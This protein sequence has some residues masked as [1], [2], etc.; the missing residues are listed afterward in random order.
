MDKHV[1]VSLN[2]HDSGADPEFGK[3]VHLVEKVEEKK[4]RSRVGKG[5]SNIPMKFKVHNY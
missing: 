3:G 2:S 5:S 4:R 1:A